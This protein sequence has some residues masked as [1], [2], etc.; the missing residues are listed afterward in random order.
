MNPSK[1]GVNT[2][3]EILIGDVS[4]EWDEYGGFCEETDR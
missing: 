4:V 2:D 3:F 1:K